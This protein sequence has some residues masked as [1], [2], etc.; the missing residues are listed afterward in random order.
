MTADPQPR[1]E[2][3]RSRVSTHNFL[4]SKTDTTQKKGN[5][6]RLTS[7]GS[8]AVTAE[9]PETCRGEAF[10][11]QAEAFIRPLKQFDALAIRIDHFLRE[12]TE[13]NGDP[14]RAIQKA[15]SSAIDRG[16]RKEDGLWGILDEDVFGC[17]FPAAAGNTGKQRAE[18]IKGLLA[19]DVDAT[20]SVG[21]ASYPTLKYGCTQIL[22]NA[23]KALDHAAF[24]GPDTVVCFDAVSLNISGD[25]LYQSGDVSG[26]AEEYRLALQLDPSNLNVLNS[27]GVCYGLLEDYD[28]ALGAFH[29]ARQVAADEVMPVYNAGLIHMLRGESEDALA[30]FRRAADL[31]PDI[32]EVAFQIGR[33]C[34]DTDATEEAVEHLRKAAALNPESGIAH[35]MLGEALEK[36]GDEEGAVSAFRTAVKKNPNDAAALSALGALYDRRGEN[37]EIAELFCRQSTEIEPENGVFLQRLGELY[38][39]HGRFPEA[40]KAFEAAQ[41]QG[42]DC[43]AQIA[44]AAQ[45]ERN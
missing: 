16:V 10:L 20:V 2:L 18:K 19:E 7:V 4:L 3:I 17:F 32:F 25:Q 43:S 40:M 26:A 37:L 5:R 6:G 22:E 31:E 39:R 27:L 28:S 21:I 36:L 9:F 13:G 44:V 34:L 38:L 35:R 42:A 29:S 45:S 33:V 14:M 30:H 12:V 23:L 11:R 24:F 1:Q 8:D 15:V 41:N